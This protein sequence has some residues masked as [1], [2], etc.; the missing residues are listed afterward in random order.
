MWWRIRGNRDVR[1]AGHDPQHGNGRSAGDER[2]DDDDSDA[3]G[4]VDVVMGVCPGLLPLF[5]TVV[6]CLSQ[7]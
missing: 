4:A 5:F 6:V 2:D 7:A 1:G 3:A